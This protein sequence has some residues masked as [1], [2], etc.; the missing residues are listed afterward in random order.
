MLRAGPLSTARSVLVRVHSSCCF[1]EV[2]GALSCDC[3]AQLELSLARI[4]REGGLLYYLRGTRLRLRAKIEAIGL[5]QRERLNTVEAY[6]RLNLPLDNRRYECVAHSLLR[7][8]IHS[9][10]LLS[11][12]PAKI[13]ALQAY[14][15]H[16]LREALIIQPEPEAQGYIETKIRKMG[17][18]WE[19][20]ASIR[21]E[22]KL[23]CE[24]S[25]DRSSKVIPS[26]SATHD[27]KP[28]VSSFCPLIQ[29]NS[30]NYP[31]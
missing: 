30:R 5:E 22:G 21:N 23:R 3:R 29:K 26:P 14:G 28:Q 12:N 19:K 8:G 27:L 7:Q 9:I 10:R 1:G 13:S 31:P 16:V 18:I 20:E 11:N 17:H 2:F 6:T 15:L 25:D 4:S 24:G